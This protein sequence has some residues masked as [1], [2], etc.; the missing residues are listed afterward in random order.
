VLDV[1]RGPAHPEL[2]AAHGQLSDQV[3]QRPVV[4]VAARLGAQ[5]ADGG[6][7]DAVPVA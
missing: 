6:V 1:V 4:R 5:A 7:G 3:G 2:L